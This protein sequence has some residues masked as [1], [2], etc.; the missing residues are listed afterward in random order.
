MKDVI[1]C[2]AVAAGGILGHVMVGA[3][4]AILMTV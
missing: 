2:F 1:I 4:P 3:V